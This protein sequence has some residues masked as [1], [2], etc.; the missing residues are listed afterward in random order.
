MPRI[1]LVLFATISAMAQ[2]ITG[3]VLDPTDAPVPATSVVLRRGKVDRS[4]QTGLAGDFKFDRVT[5]GEYDVSVTLAGFR[6]AQ[7]HLS[8]RNASLK[9]ILI[10]LELADVSTQVNVQE[11][12]GKVNVESAENL[13]A[14]TIQRDA[15]DN[16]PA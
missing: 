9:P 8:V 3:L 10:K 2:S 15:L 14:V 12:F 1:P 6:P 7:V 5:P 4:I 13:N 11:E 16:L